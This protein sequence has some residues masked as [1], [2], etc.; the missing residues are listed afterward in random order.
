[1]GLELRLGAGDLVLLRV[2]LVRDLQRRLMCARGAVAEEARV[3]ADMDRG[4]LLRLE[5]HLG[6]G[7]VGLRVGVRGRGR[8]RVR[9]RV[10]VGVGLGVGL[11]LGF[12]GWRGTP[13]RSSEKGAVASRERVSASGETL[14]SVSSCTW[15]PMGTFSSYM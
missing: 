9:V 13:L 2:L 8:G 4:A 14:V 5:S 11:G 15:S 1:M 3:E 12:C 6:R 7:G 10:R